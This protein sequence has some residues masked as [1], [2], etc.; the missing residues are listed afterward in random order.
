MLIGLKLKATVRI[1]RILLAMILKFPVTQRSIERK[2]GRILIRCDKKRI[3]ASRAVVD[4][5]ES[6]VVI[7]NDL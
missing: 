1:R 3:H 2:R 4:R 5:V 6:V 7:E